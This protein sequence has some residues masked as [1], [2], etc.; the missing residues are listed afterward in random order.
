[1]LAV[2]Q[3]CRQIQP[4]LL[5]RSVTCKFSATIATHL[6]VVVVVVAAAAV[7]VGTATPKT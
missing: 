3:P 7:L 2:N 5:P 4:P 1:M 6:V